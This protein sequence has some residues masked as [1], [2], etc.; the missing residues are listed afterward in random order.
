MPLSLSNYE[1]RHGLSDYSVQA[2]KMEEAI[3]QF[4]LKR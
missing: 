4:Q 3:T 2:I 1:R